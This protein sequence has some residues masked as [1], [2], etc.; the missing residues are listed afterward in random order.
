[1]ILFKVN[2]LICANEAGLSGGGGAYGPGDMGNVGPSTGNYSGSAG[3]SGPPTVTVEEAIEMQQ[4]I[5]QDYAKTNNITSVGAIPADHAAQISQGLT[6]QDYA[7]MSANPNLPWSTR[8][9]YAWA[10]NQAPQALKNTSYILSGLGMGWF[11]AALNAGQAAGAL[12]TMFTGKVGPAPDASLTNAPGEQKPLAEWVQDPQFLAQNQEI[13]QTG[14]ADLVKQET[15]R[16]V[17]EQFYKGKTQ[18]QQFG[19]DDFSK[20]VSQETKN[21]QNPKYRMDRGQEI[22]LPGWYKQYLVDGSLPGSGQPQAPEETKTQAPNVTDTNEVKTDSGVKG[23]SA[24]QPSGMLTKAQ[25]EPPVMGL[26]SKTDGPAKQWWE[27][28]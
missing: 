15:D 1:M 19:R 27:R 4:Q 10:A 21:I 24:T 12:Q 2:P 3:P 23:L 13:A 18:G 7:A 5:A 22:G 28:R 26:L 8:M 14:V 9:K 25:A 17:V 20:W 6:Q 16:A 11:S